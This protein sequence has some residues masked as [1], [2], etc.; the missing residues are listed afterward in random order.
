ME[1][2]SLLELDRLEEPGLDDEQHVARLA[3]KI[4]VDLGLRPPI[5]HEVVASFQGITEIRTTGAD[6]WAGCLVRDARGLIIYLRA[7]DGWRRQRYT[8][9]HE[10]GHTFLPGFAVQTQFRCAPSLGQAKRQEERL[11]DAAAG[12]LLFPKPFF[13]AD[14][15]QASFGLDAVEDLA[16]S[17]DASLAATAHRFVALWPEDCLLVILEPMLKPADRFEEA[18][19]PRLRVV[20][21]IHRGSWPYLPRFKSADEGSKLAAALDG[22]IVEG[23][24][25]GLDGLVPDFKGPAQVSARL[26]PYRDERGTEHRRVLALYR[27]PPTTA[28][29]RA[30]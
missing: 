9:C 29:G 12:E 8:T 5:N 17:Y 23:L 21:S 15:E 30:S 16:D 1:Q 24:G 20:Y 13:L 6:D 2:L 19:E 22:E 26:L 25:H 18:P 14:L 11:S 28:N 3:Q 10:V 27:K 7:S 4:V